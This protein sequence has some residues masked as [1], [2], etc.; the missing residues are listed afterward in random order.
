[1]HHKQQWQGDSGSIF[2]KHCFFSDCFHRKLRGAPT[3]DS[4]GSFDASGIVG[5]I[6]HANI[7]KVSAPIWSIRNWRKVPYSWRVSTYFCQFL[8][9]LSPYPLTDL[10]SPRFQPCLVVCRLV[11]SGVT[12]SANSQL[13]ARPTSCYG[14]WPT[15]NS[16]SRYRLVKSKQ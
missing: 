14:C 5:S 4:T 3:E 16:C 9:N 12:R 2:A 1:M 15:S 6:S 8:S 13:A 11:G 10:T 7:W